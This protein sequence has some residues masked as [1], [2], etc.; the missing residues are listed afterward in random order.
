MIY[1]TSTEKTN[2]G[3]DEV[4]ARLVMDSTSDFDNLPTYYAPGSVAYTADGAHLYILSP[5]KVWTEF[6]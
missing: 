3:L 6:E 5:S 1:P 4:E 2:N